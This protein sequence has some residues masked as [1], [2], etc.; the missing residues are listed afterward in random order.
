VRTR[1]KVKDAKTQENGNSRKKLK[2]KEKYPFSGI[3]Y[4]KAIK[5]VR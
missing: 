3:F 4:Y 2:L 5:K 1:K